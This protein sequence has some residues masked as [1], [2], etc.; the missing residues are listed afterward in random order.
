MKTSKVLLRS[1]MAVAVMFGCQQTASAQF[2]NILNK[3]KEKATKTVT[4]TAET[5]AKKAVDKAEEKARKKM[6]E[7]VKKKVLNGKQMP[8]QPW[9]MEEG[10]TKSYSWPPPAS[11]KE[12][13]ITWYLYNLPN[14]SVDEVK[15]MKAKLDARYQANAKIMKAEEAG[16]FSQ[17]SGYATKLLSEVHQEQERWDAFY[18][19]IMQF[20]TTHVQ[21][22]MRD[23]GNLDWVLTWNRGDIMVQGDK[24]LLT[25]DKN[26]S[27]KLQ[28][29]GV[30]S[31]QGV[32]ASAADIKNIKEEVDRMS[33]VAILTEGLT[34][35]FD[36]PHPTKDRVNYANQLNA[37]AKMYVELIEEALG[38]NTPDNIE[39]R[40]MPKAG[41]LNASLKA[42][43]LAEAK[44]DDP[45]V[46]DVVI[47]SNNWNVKPLERRTV[48]GYVIK[49]D[50]NGKRAFARTWC[51]DYM[52]GGKYGSLR[53][54]G[55]GMESFYLK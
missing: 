17:L 26:D 32:Y 36:D 6:W 51:Q 40:A 27:G 25:I 12:K 14:T 30:A 1:A 31:H 47:T 28:F 42:K 52:G 46:I 18:G 50:E 38:N 45:S 10:V 22:S 43:A 13:N 19:E 2:G 11:E 7:I 37:K 23:K 34:N 20:M 48:S 55:V 8:E 21:G 54:Y 49:K 29:Y 41:K 39:R 4:G 16:L 24:L 53:N 5:M 33:K 44:R 35:E 3:A 9:I 15:D